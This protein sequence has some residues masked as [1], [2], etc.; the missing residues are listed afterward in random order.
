MGIVIGIDV[1]GSTTKIV[2]VEDKKIKNPMFVKAT[3]PVTSL[4]GAFGKYIYDNNIK[5]APVYGDVIM[6]NNVYR[7]TLRNRTGCVFCGFGVQNE[8][9]PNRYQLLQQTH[10]QLHDYCMNKLGFRD[11]CEF[12]N[13][14][15]TN[16][17]E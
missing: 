16:K 5:I 15:Y 7:T 3:D 6:E 13:I 12:M 8:S 4:F 14:P 2:G 9:E 17:E 11:I 10:P 1:G